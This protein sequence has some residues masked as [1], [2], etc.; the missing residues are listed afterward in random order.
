MPRLMTSTPAARLAAIFPSSWANAYGGMRS[1]RLLGCMQLLFEVLAQAALEHG[2]RPACPVDVQIL[3]HLNLE[4]AAVEQNQHHLGG[5][6]LCTAVLQVGDRGAARA[7]ARRQGLPHPA[8]EDTRADARCA[9]T[10][11]RVELGVPG[12]V[13]PVG[14]LR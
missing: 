5:R 9:A 10:R 6:P 12:H 2:P 8:L 3:P 13:R 7:G 11:C 4:L 1:R 14:E